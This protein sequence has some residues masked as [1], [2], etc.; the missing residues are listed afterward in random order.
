MRP[1]SRQTNGTAR[2]KGKGPEAPRPRVRLAALLRGLGFLL[3]TA[4]LY[5]I[6]IAG[7]TPLDVRL[8]EPAP[9]DYRARA[10]F[11][12]LNRE[13]TR[14]ARLAARRAQP[15]VFRSAPRRWSGGV[16][17]LQE[18]LQTG[19]DALV[20]QRLPEEG[21][22]RAAFL[23]LAAGLA[24]RPDVLTA[25]LE[26]MAAGHWARPGD[27]GHE[28]MMET[29]APHVVLRAPEGGETLLPRE[30]LNA[31]EGGSPAFRE[32]LAP[33]LADLPEAQAD[34]LAAGIAHEVN[35]PLGVVL[36]YAHLLLDESSPD[37]ETRDD[38]QLIAEQAD[39]CKKIVAGL[40]HFARQNR[41][42]RAEANVCEMVDRLLKVCQIPKNVSL[43]VIH[44]LD[45]PV[46][47]VDRDQLGQVLTNLVSNSVAAMPSGGKLIVRTAGNHET[48][49]ISVADT[50]CGIPEEN[51]QK[52]F[53]PFFTTKHIGKGTGLGLAVSYGI[54]KMHRGDIHVE[55][56]ADPKAGPTGATFTVIL[57][58]DVDDEA[59][60]E[61]KGLLEAEGEQV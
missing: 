60:D 41:V 11:V 57:P 61:P 14:A 25:A 32:A 55:S 38:L 22:D 7:Q 23:E 12:H 6:L 40:L 9:R 43:R 29:T 48:V 56:N 47:R 28:L 42:I 8:G 21:F 2:A 17:A 54:V 27:L 5:S 53:E 36:M 16:E 10:P 50:G 24:A 51:R 45:N 20:W 31:L 30:A 34:L 33:I 37:A 1:D 3:F 15:P 49:S 35:N 13:R 52:I 44:E 18:G 19:P 39:R 46:A 26:R 59:A 4:A 58:R